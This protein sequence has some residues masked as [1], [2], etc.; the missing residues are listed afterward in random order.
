MSRAPDVRG[1]TGLCQRSVIG[2]VD[3]WRFF[4][5]SAAALRTH[6]ERAT[7]AAAHA[8]GSERSGSDE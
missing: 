4:E 7:G 8:A 5:H 6:R 2:S 3:D 1:P